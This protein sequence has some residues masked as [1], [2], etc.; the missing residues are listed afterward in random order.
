MGLTGDQIHPFA[1]MTAVADVYDAVTAK[2]IYYP[3]M[4]MYQALLR[5]TLRTRGQNSKKMR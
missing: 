4:P 3:S 5:I 1:R 2:W